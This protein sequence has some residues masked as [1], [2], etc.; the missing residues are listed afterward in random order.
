MSMDRNEYFDNEVEKLKDCSVKELAA[1]AKKDGIKL[2][3]KYK[4]LMQNRIASV[5]AYR[6]FPQT[7][8]PNEGAAQ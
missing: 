5:R 1:I 2:Y 6:Q 3:S 4:M 7:V 8:Y